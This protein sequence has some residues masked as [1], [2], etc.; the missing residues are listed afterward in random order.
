VLKPAGR[1]VITTPNVGSLAHRLFRR[2]C[3]HLDPPRHLYVFSTAALYE[4]AVRAGL[5]V[6]EMRTIMAMAREIWRASRII[7]RKGVLPP[8]CLKQLGNGAEPEG[9]VFQ[10]V[11]HLLC[12]AKDVGETI[13]LIATK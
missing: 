7:S 6:L 5:K 3:L 1:L 9:L 8:K 10:I 2:E 4:C 12:P 11:E 13:A